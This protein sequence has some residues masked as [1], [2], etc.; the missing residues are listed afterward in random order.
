MHRP[1]PQESR[2]PPPARAPP[3][4]DDEEWP[5]FG[6][7]EKEK[8]GDREKERRE[9]ERREQATLAELS[10]RLFQGSTTEDLESIKRDFQ[11]FLEEQKRREEE[12]RQQSEGGKPK[13][14]KPQWT[15]LR[16][17]SNDLMQRRDVI[18]SR[19]GKNRESMGKA[20]AQVE[21]AFRKYGEAKTR[22]TRLKDCLLYTSDAADE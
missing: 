5:P 16:R 19:I 17:E 18:I 3:R 15:E 1:P 21:E 2:P 13:G 6:K 20:L 10:S 11:G 7:K 9:D 4:V 22:V 14:F 12:I 8:E